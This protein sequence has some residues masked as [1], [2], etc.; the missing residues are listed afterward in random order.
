MLSKFKSAIKRS[1]SK[2][3]MVNLDFVA[4]QENSIIMLGW[5]AHKSADMSLTDLEIHQGNSQLKTRIFTFSRADVN[6]RFQLPQPGCCFGFLAVIQ[7]SGS[8]INQLKIGHSE[9]FFKVT[10]LNFRQ[11]SNLA[12]IIS[13]IPERRE[14]AQKFVEKQ[15]LAMG[16]RSASEKIVVRHRDKD[17][18]KIKGILQGIDIARSGALQSLGSDV[19]SDVHRIWKS[20]QSKNNASELKQFGPTIK[21]PSISVIIPL[22]GRYDFMQHQLANFSADNSMSNAEVIF[23][24]DDPSLEREVLIT[25]HGLFE[26]FNYPFKL[27]LSERNRGFAGANNLGV[28]YANSETLLLL[29]SDILPCEQGWI[30]SYLAQFSAIDNVGI[31][32]ATL[33]YED[34]TIQHA[35]MEFRE[36]SHYPGIWMN[37][38][39]Y[40][41]IPVKLV[42]LGDYFESQITTGACMM[43]QTSLYREL[44]GFDPMYVLG[45]FEDSDLCLKVINKGLKIM[46]SGSVKL[47]HLERLSQDLVDSGDW[48]F[49]LTLMNG[50]YQANK[51]HGL[52]E[53]ITQ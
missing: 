50:V 13:H 30:K 18:E 44:G 3:A 26:T 32:G 41:G 15:G 47:F 34:E 35:G 45:D 8:D 53:E 46:V 21:S 40:K 12:E 37:H 6:Q 23:V 16:A 7:G 20:K 27:V 42:D 17:V 49:K 11:A 25:A 1:L 24:L 9:T 10:N 2:D 4:L 51:W 5:Y 43:M 33:I 29:N 48:K 52:I 38:H 14:E 39:P 28:E 22:Y 19:M 36:D 31:L